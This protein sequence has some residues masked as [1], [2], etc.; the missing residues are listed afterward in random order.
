VEVDMDREHAALRLSVIGALFSA[1]LGIAFFF[2]TDSEAILLD[3]FFS[4]I[5]FGMGLLTIRVARLVQQPD[6]ARF[7]FGYAAFEPLL[8]A[9]KGLV[10]LAVCAFAFASAVGAVLGGGREVDAGWG[11][12]YA[13]IAAV[14]CFAIAAYQRRVARTTGSAL[15][16]VDAKSWLVD[17]FMSLVVAGAFVGAWLIQGT[18][19]AAAGPLV[20]PGL[21][22]VLVILMIGVPVRI[23]LRGLGEL[24]KAAPEEEVQSDI[25]SRV[26]AVLDAADL[27]KRV[28]RMVRIGREFWLL[29]HILVPADRRVCDVADLDEIRAAI[30]DAVADTQPGLVVDT[31]FTSRKEWVV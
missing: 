31:V 15:V 8:N 20:D 7:Q 4:F 10:I 27:P 2:L 24:L 16:E 29:N 30:V 5:G 22:M 23:V 6:D 1:V 21:V 11:I 9:I 14:A 17:G 26:E 3:G 18:R 19:W 28:I 25:R 13:G 12:A